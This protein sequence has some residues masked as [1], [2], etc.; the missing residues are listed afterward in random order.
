[1]SASN[2]SKRIKELQKQLKVEL[3]KA[4]VY[5]VSLTPKGEQTLPWADR[6]L[7]DLND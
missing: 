7:D 3:V 5:S 2:A 1:M 4:D 6:V